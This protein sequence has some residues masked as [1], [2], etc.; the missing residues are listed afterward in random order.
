MQFSRTHF[1]HITEIFKLV[2]ERSARSWYATGYGSS[3][4]SGTFHQKLESQ[5][6][7]A[8]NSGYHFLKWVCMMKRAIVYLLTIFQIITSADAEADT[9]AYM[10]AVSDCIIINLLFI[11][12]LLVSFQMEMIHYWGY[13]AELHEA[14]TPDGYILGMFRIPHGRFSDGSEFRMPDS[15]DYIYRK[16]GATNSDYTN[17][18]SRL[19]FIVHSSSRCDGAWIQRRIDR[20]HCESASIVAWS[21]VFQ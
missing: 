3:D 20:I 4:H 14:L 17:Y 19:R 15:E 13:P 9:K 18:S 11:Q 6:R 5:T 1:H 16:K 7:I 10:S 12:S 8:I 21:V 2:I